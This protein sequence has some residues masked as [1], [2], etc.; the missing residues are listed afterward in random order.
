[1]RAVFV[2]DEIE[3]NRAGVMC[4]TA[5]KLEVILRASLPRLRAC[6]YYT[7]LRPAWS[8]DNMRK[9]DK[10]KHSNAH[11]V[12]HTLTWVLPEYF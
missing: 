2:N 9:P 12:T 1:M 6:W 11:F 10:I 7:N 8:A 5:E 4:E 3:L